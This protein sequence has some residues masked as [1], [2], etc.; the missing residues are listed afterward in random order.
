[1]VCEPP[2][3]VVILMADAASVALSE[4][5]RLLANL[6]NTS[7]AL[8]T[9]SPSELFACQRKWATLIK[10]SKE[11]LSEATSSIEREFE[12]LRSRVADGEKLPLF[13]DVSISTHL[14][15]LFD[16]LACA[17]RT[18]GAK[19]GCV[20]LEFSGTLHV[21]TAFTTLVSEKLDPGLPQDLKEICTCSTSSCLIAN[22]KNTRSKGSF[23]TGLV[24]PIVIKGD[25]VGVCCFLDKVGPHPFSHADEG[26]IAVVASLLGDYLYRKDL[27]A[28]LRKI[29]SSIPFAPFQEEYN[30]NTIGK[31]ESIEGHRPHF[32]VRIHRQPT[33]RPQWNEQIQSFVRYPTDIS[34]LIIDVQTQLDEAKG[35]QKLTEERLLSSIEAES[36]ANEKLERTMKMLDIAVKDSALLRL[37]NKRLLSR[38]FFEPKLSNEVPASPPRDAT[39]P[40]SPRWNSA[41][42]HV[43][44]K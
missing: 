24:A 17:T 30:V 36:K 13:N 31:T 26:A 2:L 33:T 3:L 20:V 11:K 21:V 44:S 25:A 28:L 27:I 22:V 42:R 15:W 40:R 35:Q 23:H 29:H 34:S 39:T 6:E 8:H 12:Y 1:M 14:R 16:L 43:K 18:A 32:S 41:A 19:R 5:E 4:V 10:V 38:S 37:A 7:S 9:M